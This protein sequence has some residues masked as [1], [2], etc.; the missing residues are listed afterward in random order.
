MKLFR[1]NPLVL[2]AFLALGAAAPAHAT[3]LE[4]KTL[5]DLVREAE[6]IFEGV[7][8]DVSHRVSDVRGP[9]DA[10]LPHTFVTFEVEH[11]MKGAV[12]QGGQITLRF[13]GGPDGKGRRLRVSGIP[14]FVPGDRDVLFV[15]GNGLR[16]CPLVGCEQGRLRQVRGNPYDEFG[17]EIWLTPGPA[18]W[19]GPVGID[20]GDWPY[21]ERRSLVEIT[22]ESRPLRT[23]PPTASAR[24]DASGLRAILDEMARTLST[25]TS[26]ATRPVP[27]A[28]ISEPFHVPA[29]VP[30]PMS[31]KN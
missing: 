7:V 23:E 12:A 20:V 4:P 25:P 1:P 17:R 6:L 29:P 11:V 3:T 10:A 15:A 28:P 21:A 2:F 5:K 22:D 31:K 26:D 14:E 9:Q 13:V 18:L 24:P 30:A 27:S 8:A 16:M 19:F